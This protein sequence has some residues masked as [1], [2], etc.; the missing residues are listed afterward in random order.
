[1]RGEIQ[2]VRRDVI[3]YILDVGEHSCRIAFLADMQDTACISLMLGVGEVI[4]GVAEEYEP[5]FPIDLV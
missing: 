3:E 1:M 4:I 5:F 2:P